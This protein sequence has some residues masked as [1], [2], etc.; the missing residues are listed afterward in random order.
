MGK[1]PEKVPVTMPVFEVICFCKERPGG[2]LGLTIVLNV[3]AKSTQTRL[4]KGK[5]SRI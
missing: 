3:H 5:L 2:H 4:R 1:E